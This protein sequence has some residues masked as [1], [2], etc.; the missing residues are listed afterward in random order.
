MAALTTI[1]IPE[2]DRRL[3]ALGS[4]EANKIVRSALNRGLTV[5][6][7]AE[8]A[9]IDSAAG[10]SADLKRAMKKTVGKRLVI[11]NSRA[12]AVQAKA[13]LGVGQK[14]ARAKAKAAAASAQRSAGNSKGVGISANNVHWFALGTADRYQGVRD[15][16]KADTTKR[17]STKTMTPKFVGR[18]KPTDVIR[19]AAPALGRVFTTV[20]QA[21]RQK[22]DEAVIRLRGQG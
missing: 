4:R 18:I 11:A 6:A 5:L 3:E 10:L 15:A 2:L 19:K 20:E 14:T 8:K 22:V 9:S 7:K 17:A 13:G 21:A 1:G 12:L 16:D